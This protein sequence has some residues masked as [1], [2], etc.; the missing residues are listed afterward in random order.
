M[1]KRQFK[2]RKPKQSR[3]VNVGVENELEL[4]NGWANKSKADT[5]SEQMRPTK[6]LSPFDHINELNIGPTYRTKHWR[7]V[8]TH[9][10]F[11]QRAF[12]SEFLTDAKNRLERKN[13]GE[14]EARTS[15]TS[16]PVIR[17]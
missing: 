15:Y 2:K 7:P 5:N 12:A 1:Q 9:I 6:T 8:D 4:N 3:R 16:W 14:I 17:K 11:G 13:R 10:S